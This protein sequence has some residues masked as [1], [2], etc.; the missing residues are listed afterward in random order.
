MTAKIGSY[1]SDG[2]GVTA[3]TRHALYLYRGQRNSA[4]QVDQML[5]RLRSVEEAVEPFGVVL[6][7]KR[8]LDVG[9]GQLL[10]Q[11]A[12]FS[13]RNDAIG[14][15]RDVIAQGW[16]PPAYVRMLR[17]N[18]V[19]RTAKT[20]VRKALRIDARFRAELAVRIGPFGRLDARQMDAVNLLGSYT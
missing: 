2:N 16:E 5:R 12:Y 14:I 4:E 11:L 20:I 17:V 18:G 1:T 15:D 8:I 19:R 13:R 7:G 9:T 3:L 10:G 6:A